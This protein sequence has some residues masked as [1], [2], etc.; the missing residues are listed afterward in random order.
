[1]AMCLESVLENELKS[2]LPSNI[3]NFN[4]QNDEVKIKECETIK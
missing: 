3:S 2:D 4:E 1:M